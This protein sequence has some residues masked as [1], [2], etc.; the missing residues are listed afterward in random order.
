M[1]GTSMGCKDT[2]FKGNELTKQLGIQL[3]VI[4]APMFLVSNECML[5]EALLSG[6][7]GVFPTLNFR[8]GN[9]LSQV[10]TDLHAIK[11][12][13]GAKGNFGVNLIVQKTNSYLDNHLR[14]CVS[15][16]VP[17]YITSL[18]SPQKV[19][20][21]ARS[22]GAK[23]YCDVTNLKH[24]EKCA[25]LGCDGFVAVGQGAG[26][27]AGP[28]P[29]TVLIPALSREF[30]SI[31]VVAAGGIATGAG[32]ISSL[33]LG[34][35]G[36]SIGTLFIASKEAGISD[37][38]K[39][40]VVNAGM[41]DIVMTERLSGTPCSIIETP[42][43]RKIGYKQGVLEKYLSRNRFTRKY[44]KAL[45]HLQGLKRLEQALKPGNYNNLWCAGKSSELIDGIRSVSEIVSKLE[46]EMR[47]SMQQLSNMFPDEG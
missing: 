26:G 11:Q 10:I 20:E 42:F 47:L 36:V 41:D 8:D 21:Q 18:G 19:I 46:S 12:E 34:A 38:Y 22:Y 39:N 29:L 25:S 5:R 45:V 33:A 16:K 43:A 24:A 17:F 3:P 30:P 23:V 31:P 6:I 9:R 1:T 28:H 2:F 44:F 40:A 37:E 35:Q 32:I 15:S 7:M 13:K 4:M 27:H 14:I